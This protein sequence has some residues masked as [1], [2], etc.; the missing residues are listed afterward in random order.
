MVATPTLDRLRHAIA[1]YQSAQ[2]RVA[3]PPSAVLHGQDLP[4]IEQIL[5]G[6]WHDTPHGPV[7]LR[8]DWFPLNHTHGIIALGGVLEAD[9]DALAALLRTRR[10]PHPERYAFFDIETTGLSGGTGTYVVLAGMGSFERTLPGEPP[11]FRLRQYFLAGPQHE[12]AML[13]MLAEDLA[14]FEAVVT[15]NG[16]AFDVPV[17]ETRLT[18]ARLPSPYRGMAHLDLL[19]PVRRLYAHRMP[20]CR[21]AEAERRLLRLDRPDDVPGYLIPALYRDYLLAGRAS[22]LRGVFRHNAEDVLSLV[23]VL[24][25]LASLIARD[26]HDPDDA[27]AVGRWCERAGQPRRAMRLYRAAL[28]WIEGGDDWAWAAS[29]HAM[30]CKRHQPREE[31]VAIW[32]RLWEA[33]DRVAG[34]ELAKHLEHR[35]RAFE[36]AAAVVTV[37]LQNAGANGE[38]LSYRLARIQR[39]SERRS[40]R[41][42]PPRPPSVA[43]SRR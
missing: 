35:E 41:P 16:S 14:R 17:V 22:P 7:F 21:L 10:A 15:Y 28:P 24:A 12:R 25:A 37:L 9:P 26:D 31:A 20:G 19:H 4:P 8:D 39:R 27:V 42:P 29:R 32:R 5:R 36:E 33:G 23:G 43:G 34:L 2:P 1:A 3:P 18:L 40:A 11:S 30:L 13:H 6:E 38:D